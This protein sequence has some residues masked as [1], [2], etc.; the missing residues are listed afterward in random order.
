MRSFFSQVLLSNWFFLVILLTTGALLYYVEGFIA[1][2]FKLLLFI[3]YII[4][5]MLI[6]FHTSFKIASS[7]TQELR[8]IEKKTMDINAGDFGTLLA[9]SDIQELSDLASSINSMSNRLQMQFTDLNVEKEKFN[10]LLQN[11]KEG[12][13]AISLDKK[14]LFQNQSIP[15]SLI[16]ANSQSR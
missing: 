1:P 3:L 14:I 2:E 7:V 15:K 8:S 6:A 10:S 12:V 16:P 5:S 11:L 9:A 13:F 4:F